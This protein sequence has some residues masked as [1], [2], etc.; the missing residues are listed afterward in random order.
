MGHR[1][2][3]ANLYLV[4]TKNHPCL[5]H[6]F[7]VHRLQRLGSEGIRKASELLKD[8]EKRAQHMNRGGTDH[9]VAV[10]ITAG[11]ETV[12]IY[13]L[14]LPSNGPGRGR[15]ELLGSPDDQQG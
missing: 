15:R 7:D 14:G 13:D 4:S 1:V 3:S 10:L 8:E 2:N 9:D 11:S 12:Y 5:G 6:S